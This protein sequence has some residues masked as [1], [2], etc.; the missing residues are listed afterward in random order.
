MT[1]TTNPMMVRVIGSISMLGINAIMSPKAH[2]RAKA[3]KAPSQSPFLSLW[4]RNPI[5]VTR[6]K[7]STTTRPMT[8][9]HGLPWPK[10]IKQARTNDAKARGANH[11]KWYFGRN[12][13]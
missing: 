7:N 10:A 8:W 1:M 6:S 3:R 4:G 5:Q 2:I 13:R 9:A 12:C 11:Q